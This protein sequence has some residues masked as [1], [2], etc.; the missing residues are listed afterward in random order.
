MAV[1]IMPN[2]VL[3]GAGLIMFGMVASAGLSGLK[4]VEM[5]TRNMLV[6]A[7]SL[8]LGMGVTVRPAML[9]HFPESI[10]TLLSSG[11]TTG[12][13]VAVFLNLLLPREKR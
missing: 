1:A 12:T 4:S 2:P 8:T 5:N 13:L 7:L 6:L 3:G 11:I 9:N 10:R